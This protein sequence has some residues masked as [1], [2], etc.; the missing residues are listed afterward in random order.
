MPTILDLLPDY[1]ATLLARGHSPNGIRRYMDQLKAFARF[2]GTDA[3]VADVTARVIRRYQERMAETCGAGSI[4]N[5]LTAIRSFC[6]WCLVE[7]LRDDDPTLKIVWPRLRKPAPRALRQAQLRHLMKVL[8]EPE[9]LT[10]KQSWRW[11]RNR[12][13]IFLMLFGGLRIAETTG[14]RWGDVDLDAGM[15]LVVDGKGGKDRG[16]PIHPVLDVELRRVESPLPSWAVVGRGEGRPMNQKSLAHI[17]ERWLPGLGIEITA[18][19]L[20]HSF[21]TELL[22]HGADLR[23]IQELLG[24]TSLETTQRYLML[25]NDQLQ[26]AIARLPSEW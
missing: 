1:R 17:F 8:V 24:H 19:Q 2:A 22:R 20:R 5:A 6:R 15:L 18:H 11:C 23:A 4:S 13:A 9:G 16:V 25:T 10:T 12:R 7:E 26:G 21:A 3:T 14:L